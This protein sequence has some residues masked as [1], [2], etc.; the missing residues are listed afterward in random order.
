MRVLCVKYQY[1]Y[2]YI[3]LFKHDIHDKM[4]FI[5]FH[6]FAL[7]V[8]LRFTYSRRKWKLMRKASIRAHQ[9]SYHEYDEP[10]MSEA[11]LLSRGQ[12][13]ING[14]MYDQL[15][16]ECRHTS[17]EYREL[18][19]VPKGAKVQDRA[20]GDGMSESQVKENSSNKNIASS[21]CVDEN[22]YVELVE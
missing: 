21:S 17:H 1:R 3:L 16:T 9:C 11:P 4:Y 15:M 2:D 8:M 13:Q 10:M 7:N 22:I 6:C 12:P 5:V 20:P 18:L 14:L 19:L